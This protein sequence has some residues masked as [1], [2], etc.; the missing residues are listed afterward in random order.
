[1]KTKREIIELSYDRIQEF[2]DDLY[3]QNSTAE[4]NGD[5]YTHIEKINQS[6]FS[7]GES[8]DFIIKRN[9]DGKFFKLHTWESS[10]GMVFSND[11]NTIE[12]VFPKT[13]TV[14]K[15]E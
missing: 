4:L 14:T 9:S 7:D 5:T 8:W 10:H 11:K 15:Y 2:W 13:V 1:M 6:E 3:F 12:E